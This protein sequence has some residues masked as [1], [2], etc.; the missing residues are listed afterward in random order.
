M[1]H[2]TPAAEWRDHLHAFEVARMPGSQACPPAAL[3]KRTE[4]KDTPRPR[5]GI[6]RLQQ[7]C[8]PEMWRTSRSTRNASGNA[9]TTSRRNAETAREMNKE[10]H[11]LGPDWA[12]LGIRALRS[13]VCLQLYCSHISAAGSE[14]HR[15]GKKVMLKP[16]LSSVLCVIAGGVSR[17]KSSTEKPVDSEWDSE[18]E[19]AAAEAIFGGRRKV[20]RNSM[21][22][23]K[24][25]GRVP[26]LSI[27]QQEALALKL[28]RDVPIGHEGTSS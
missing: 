24:E 20:R 23:K 8:G 13:M 4:S 21:Q 26:H 1:L 17:K 15:Q 12:T 22:G 19:A 25:G 10:L 7:S 5:T 28:L 16:L 14:L 27:A 3:H 2:N 18:L 9:V 11:F 6:N